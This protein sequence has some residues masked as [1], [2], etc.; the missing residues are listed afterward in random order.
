MK[1]KHFDIDFDCRKEAPF[2]QSKPDYRIRFDIEK[3]KRTT[4]QTIINSMFDAGEE[5]DM[6]V[7]SQY[8][9]DKGK[10]LSSKS[11]IGKIITI[12]NWNETTV[13]DKET[14]E[15][16]VYANIKRLNRADVNNYCLAVKKGFREAY[17]SFFSTT[18]LLYVS[19]D[20]IDIIANNKAEISNLKEEYRESY[21]KYYEEDNHH[22]K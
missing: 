12:K 7:I 10:R 17:I 18:F 16:V 5:I 11:N 15:G 8:I 13:I 4:L 22:S 20:V 1:L 6:I 2:F 3:L 19:S 21:D 14:N 9:T